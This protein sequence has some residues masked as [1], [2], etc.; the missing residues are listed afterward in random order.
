M[1]HC[2]YRLPLTA[3]LLLAL[4]PGASLA[5][6][7]DTPDSGPDPLL[8]DI[9]IVGNTRTD[10]TVILREMGLEIGQPINRKMM[11][12]AWIILED[13]GYFAFVDMEFD[14]SDDDGVVL[15]VE[16]VEDMT[17]AYGPLVR[18][19]RRHK[20]L[21]GAW[22]E[23]TNLRGKG[24]TLRVDLAGLYIQR[25]EVSWLRPWMFGVGGLD[26]K[27]GV[28]AEQ[29]NFV[30]RPTDQR[31]GRGDLELRWNF[32][33]DL[34][35]SGGLNYGQT[36]FLDSYWWDD[37]VSG[38]GVYHQAGTETHLASRMAVG[39]DSRDNP[40][41]PASGV[42]AEA[43][44]QRWNSDD[45]QSFTEGLGE[46]RLFIPSPLASH[47]LA[48]RAWG[49]RTSGRTNLENNLFFGGPETIRGYQ[50]AG[51]EGDEGYLLSAE[52]RMPLFMMPISPK[53]EMVGFGLHV[54]ADAGDAWHYGVDPQRALQ[55]WGGGAHLNLD[56]MQLR[57][58]A[59]KSRDG[60]WVFEFMDH[61]NF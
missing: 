28:M 10:R 12:Q 26:L 44:I 14:D 20:Y 38:E 15:Q 31:L 5:V 4:A 19:D 39:F 57:F 50:F 30:F 1:L 22:L 56:R 24:E 40:W 58:E 35:V 32:L 23:E 8:K 3:L 43:T 54:F 18:Y 45:Y 13:V 60:D 48:L 49:R 21:L 7:G 42:M 55:S 17:T 59:A 51:Q 41:Y 36:K 33:G 25:G 46:V 2:R 11:D 47:I 29:S 53:G 9:A 37:P 61:F 16:V 52:Y 34:Y 27:I 6:F